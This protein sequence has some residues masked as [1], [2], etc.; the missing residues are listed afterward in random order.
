MASHPM[1]SAYT[2]DFSQKQLDNDDLT[3]LFET[4][5]D[6]APALV[7]FEDLDRLFGKVPE[8][9]NRTNI[10][11]QHLL[12]CL[13]GLATFDGLIVVATANDQTAL[14]AAILRRPGRFDRAVLFQKPT[15][16]I[17]RKYLAR[18]A[19]N[20]LGKETLDWAAHQTNQMSFAQLREI[21]ILAGETA[22]RTKTQIDQT[23]LAQAIQVVRDEAARAG[24]RTDARGVGYGPTADNLVT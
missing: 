3:Y 19:G 6:H 5:A 24:Q 10:T 8:T 22:F 23:G 1:L 7:I 16:E 20:V 14:D 12:S 11:F 21:Y 9:D 4:A 18:L 13:D 17:R 15:T 2:L